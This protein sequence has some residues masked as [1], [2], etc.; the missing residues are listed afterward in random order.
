MQALKIFLVLAAAFGLVDLG[1]WLLGGETMTQ[2]I[3]AAA[4]ADPALGNWLI[5]GIIV[6]ALFLIKHFELK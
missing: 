4:D 1:A 3:I 6:G 2:C 5:A